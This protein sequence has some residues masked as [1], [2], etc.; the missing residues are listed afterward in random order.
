[1]AKIDYIN[2]WRAE[3]LKGRKDAFVQKFEAK[4]EEKQYSAISMWKSYR[5]RKSGKSKSK[6]SNREPARCVTMALRALKNSR[7]MAI[8]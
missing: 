8:A 5:L 4:S 6:K 7:G 1:M 2:K 3:Y